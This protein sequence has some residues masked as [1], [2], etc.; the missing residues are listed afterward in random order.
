M[1]QALQKDRPH[2]LV[3]DDEAEL[4]IALARLL[5]R[6]GYEA[7]ACHTIAAAQTHLQTERVDLILTDLRMPGSGGLDLLRWARQTRTDL[8]IVL[9]TAYGTVEHAVEA[10]REG[11][12]DFLVKPISRDSLLSTV[13]RALERSQL[14]AENASLRA[15]VAKLTRRSPIIGRSSAMATARRIA[16]Q[17][18]A[19]DATLMITGESG[20]GKEVFAREVHALSSRATKPFVPVHCA[21]LPE[22]IIEAEL[23]GHEAGAFTGANRRRIGHIEAADG[24]S[25]FLDEIAEIP[26]STQVKLLRVLQEQEVTRLGASHPTRVNVRI[27]AATHQDLSALVASGKFREDLYYR[28]QVIDLNLPPLREREDDV[29]LLAN[30]LLQEISTLQNRSAPPWS[31]AALRH[32]VNHPWPGNVRELRNVI[33]RALALDRD[34]VLDVDDLPPTLHQPRAQSFSVHPGMT[35]AEVERRLVLATLNYAEGDK[36]RAAQMLGI[37]RRTIYRKLDDYEQQQQ[38]DPDDESLP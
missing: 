36:A 19:T 9:M 24:G 29:V 4:A 20:T 22:T 13:A 17:A 28:L 10:M 32:L 38:P 15:Q 18:A 34:G 1:A 35:M 33:E 7:T 16:A 26:L 2:V 14:K 21:A 37:G 31:D 5:R 12:V 25:L 27:I 6:S 30:Q 23:F 8:P 3:I 11:A